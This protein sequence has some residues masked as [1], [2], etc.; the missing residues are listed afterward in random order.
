VFVE[1]AQVDSALN[2]HDYLNQSKE[3]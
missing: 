3:D 1:V 2:P